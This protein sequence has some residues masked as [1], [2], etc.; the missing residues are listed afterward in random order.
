MSA[1]DYLDGERRVVALSSHAELQL[2]AHVLH[3]RDVEHVLFLVNLKDVRNGNGN[4][5]G[6]RKWV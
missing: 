1:V 4:G 5:S 2:V 3:Q 6:G